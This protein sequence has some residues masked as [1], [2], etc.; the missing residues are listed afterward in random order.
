MTRLRCGCSLT[1]EPH[2]HIVRAGRGAS[3]TRHIHVTCPTGVAGRISIGAR[4][5]YCRDHIAIS[6]RERKICD[7]PARSARCSA[8]SKHGVRQLP[9]AALIEKWLGYSLMREAHRHIV[10]ASRGASFAH[11]V[12][13]LSPAGVAGGISIGAR[14]RYGRNQRAVAVNVDVGRGRPAPGETHRIY[15]PNLALCG[16]ERDRSRCRCRRGCRSRRCRRSRRRSWCG[17][18]YSGQDIYPAPAIDVVWRAGSAALGRRNKMS[19]VI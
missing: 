7:T 10:R 14:V 12:D 17:A 5:A 13:V 15:S 9:D 11:V 3:F 4:V 18:G 19:R 8:K 16:A 1:P 6:T 2:C